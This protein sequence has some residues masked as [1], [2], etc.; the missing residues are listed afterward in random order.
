MKK[1]SI[2]VSLFLMFFALCMNVS[3]NVYGDF[4]YAVNLPGENG[5]S[6]ETLEYQSENSGDEYRL[7]LE[8]IWGEDNFEYGILRAYRGALLWEF[9]P[10]GVVMTELDGI[11]DAYENGDTV[12]IVIDRVLH[13]LEKE[14][15]NIKW[16][17]E[18]VGAGNR[19]VFDD[20]GNIYVSG[21]YGPNIVVFSKN[22][23]EL[24]RS[25]GGE[26]SWVSDLEISGNILNIKY[27]FCD[28]RECEGVDTLD[29]SQF[30]PS[31]IFVSVNGNDVVF[32]QEPVIESG[33]TL[34]PLRA[35]FEALG[36]AV[37]WNDETKTVTSSKGNIN[38]L[39]IIGDNRIF[40]NGVPKQ[41]DVSARIMGGRTMVPV[42]AVSEAF[43]CDVG[44][45]ENERRVIITSEKS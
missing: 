37:D 36:A 17:G 4:D 11:S 21:Y 30:Y 41:L 28:D 27:N 1:K 31:R 33:R 42:R 20:Y 13:A 24:Y 45:N 23:T 5:D 15:G 44:W 38:I 6:T 7:E 35:I 18:N 39:L 22:G 32:D 25:P 19:I 43:G 8:K 10:E 3:A 26:Y 9:K 12:Y 2:I 16:K 29:I 14:T 34:V 40:V